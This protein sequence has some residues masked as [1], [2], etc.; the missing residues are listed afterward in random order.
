MSANNIILIGYRGS[1]KSSVGRK[2]A[3]QL[4]KTLCD[5]DQGVRDRFGG[6]SIAEIWATEGEPAF[7]EAEEAVTV[8]A[9]AGSGL[10][11]ALGGGSLMRPGARRAVAASDG[12]RIYLRCEPAELARRIAADPGSGD[13]RP[14]LTGGG[15]AARIEEIAAVLAEREPV[16][17]EVADVEFDVTLTDVDEA[18]RHLIARHL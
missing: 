12:V 6:R 9:C 3:D 14:G 8:A 16:Y 13:Q 10:V 5:T 17:R 11:I 7:R 1:G 4:W 2:L 15:G 18:V